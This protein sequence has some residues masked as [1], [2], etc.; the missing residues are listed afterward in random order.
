[1]SEPSAQSVTK[2]VTGKLGQTG[3]MLHCRRAMKMHHCSGNV[4][5]GNHRACGKCIGGEVSRGHRAQMPWAGGFFHCVKRAIP[6]TRSGP[7]RLPLMSL[8]IRWKAFRDGAIIPSP[9]G[10]GEV[11]EW[12]NAP[13]SKTGMPERASRVRIS[14]SP[15]NRAQCRCDA[16]PCFF[17]VGMLPQTVGQTFLSVQLVARPGRLSAIP[18]GRPLGTCVTYRT[19]YF[20]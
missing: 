13:V 17:L 5:N 2:T 4:E 18:G 8:E 20:S 10:N 11:A 1:M 15:L 9:Q 7:E 19:P 3:S 12:P 16:G 6:L 14:P